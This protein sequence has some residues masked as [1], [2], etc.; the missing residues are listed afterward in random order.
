MK[1][2]PAGM[3]GDTERPLLPFIEGDGQN[4]IHIQSIGLT[5]K[6]TP[7]VEDIQNPNT[8]KLGKHLKRFQC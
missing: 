8:R 2:H 5:I 7:V 4:F 3:K 6:G 1:P